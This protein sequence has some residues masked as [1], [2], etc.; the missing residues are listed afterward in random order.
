M[1]GVRNILTELDRVDEAFLDD[2]RTRVPVMSQTLVKLRKEGV[3]DFMTASQL[4]PAIE[5]VEALHEVAGL[6]QAGMMTMFLQGLRSFLLGAAYR[7]TTSLAERLETIEGRIQ[8]LIP[9]AEQWV[10]IG[11]IERVAISE[12]LPV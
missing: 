7:K 11:R 3:E 8:A 12:I 2:V 1:I 9:M 10:N 6:V 5:Q 4:D